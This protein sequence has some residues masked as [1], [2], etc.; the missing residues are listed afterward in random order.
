MRRRNSEK[1]R[2]ITPK[3]ARYKERCRVL[4]KMLAARLVAE[5]GSGSA[6]KQYYR[7]V[8]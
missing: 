8:L 3:V 5:E 2:G 7:S 1:R 6:T 4:T